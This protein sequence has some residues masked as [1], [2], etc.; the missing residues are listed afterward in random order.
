MSPLHVELNKVRK[1]IWA[2]LG[3]AHVSLAL[4]WAGSAACVW[5]VL[6]RLFPVLS[7]TLEVS[8]GLLVAAIAF[9][10]Y[11]TWRQRPDMKTAALAA[12]ERL[13]L[14][15]RLTSSLELQNHE[16]PMVQAVHKDAMKHLGLLN[17]GRDFPL[18]PTRSTR[19]A[20]VPIL[21]FG[22][23]YVLL[24]EFDLF[25]Y[26]ERA[27]QA[28][29]EMAEREKKAE[30]LDKAAKALKA[31]DKVP[32]SNLEAKAAQ[33]E[34]LSE[35]LK[36]GAITEKQALA[37]VQS[38]KDTL[39]QERESLAS[40][41]YLNKAGDKSNSASPTE[42][43]SKDLQQ[44][45][46]S[47]AKKKM[48]E[49]KKKLESGKL[50]EK[51]K[52]ELA[53]E[54]KEMAKELG[55]NGKTQMDAALSAAL[56]KA[57]SALSSDS[58][59]G[60]KE[61]MDSLEL[62]MKDMESVM[63]QLAQLDAAMASLK[64]FEKGMMGSSPFCRSCG[65][66][67]GECDKGKACEGACE[68]KDCS[69]TCGAGACSGSGAGK[70]GYQ[71][72]LGLGGG[73]KGPGMGGPGQGR[74]NQV[75][76]LPDVNVAMTPTMLPGEVNEGKMLASILQKTAPDTESEANVQVLSGVVVQAQQEAEEALTREEIPRG[77]A[78]FVRQYFGTL[79]GGQPAE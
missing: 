51:E 53:S 66:K 2:Q 59:E 47:E 37:K 34:T 67:L 28:K 44:G 68:G 14:R 56:A 32:V 33:L 9:A 19:W 45:N 75:G 62:S 26:E 65:A 48:E 23:G 54:L 58:P 64:E 15:E 10:L 52:A 6:C 39:Q 22:L 61:A 3:V 42:G 30:R 79:E 16:H 21:L 4:L 38:L 74:G 50:S 7:L 60:M 13:G 24:P 49:L 1:R 46:M 20:V 17:A 55:Q 36:A 69:G 76:E 41:S 63:E 35:A 70:M 77:S 57:A 72:G 71:K 40:K 43:L 73:G 12:D 11:Q 5:L 29:V 27:L 31:P 78:E 25:G 18:F 8:G